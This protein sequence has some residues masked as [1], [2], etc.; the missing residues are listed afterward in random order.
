MNGLKYNITYPSTRTEADDLGNST[1]SIKFNRSSSSGKVKLAFISNTASTG[2]CLPRVKEGREK[3]KSK[4]KT[5]QKYTFR[6]MLATF[7]LKIKH[8]VPVL[9]M[10][11]SGYNY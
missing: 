2:T 11:F 8:Q 5:K 4:C 7:W 9:H 3:K 10:K 1:N 6:D